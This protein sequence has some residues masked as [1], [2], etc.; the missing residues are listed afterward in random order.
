MLGGDKRSY[1]LKQTCSWKLQICLNMY[2][3]LLPFGINTLIA[4]G[5]SQ[6]GPYMYL[7]NHVFLS[8]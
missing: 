3:V 7:S 8:Q 6:T 5:F 4:E 2:D 1:K